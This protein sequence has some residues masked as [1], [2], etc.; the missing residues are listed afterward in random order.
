MCRQSRIKAAAYVHYFQVL[1]QASTFNLTG[2]F[3]HPG[4]QYLYFKH[5]VPV[6]QHTV[7]GL[8]SLVKWQHSHGFLWFFYL[9]HAAPPVTYTSHVHPSRVGYPGVAYKHGARHKKS[10]VHV[11]V[12][13]QG[14]LVCRLTT[15]N[16]CFLHERSF[17][18]KFIYTGQSGIFTVL[19][20]IM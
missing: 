3:K 1:V 16:M 9:F 17:Y 20:A 14:Q 7:T 2:T 12:T 18:T 15:P 4:S 10:Y 6:S 5:T 13:I 11:G 8:L 19:K